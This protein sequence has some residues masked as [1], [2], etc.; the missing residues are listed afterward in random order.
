MD[1]INIR[2]DIH[3]GMVDL[4]GVF[5]E[6]ACPTAGS[7]LERLPHSWPARLE[8]LKDSSAYLVMTKG[9]GVRVCLRESGEIRV[10]LHAGKR[11]HVAL[12]DDDNNNDV[13]DDIVTYHGHPCLLHV[14][15]RWTNPL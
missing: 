4:K 7:P 9:S 6:C 8:A 5:S 1:L 3:Q 15:K 12:D 14:G 13:D 11:D 2:T 10:C